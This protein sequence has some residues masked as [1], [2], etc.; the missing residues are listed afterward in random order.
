[1]GKKKQVMCKTCYRVMRSDNLNRHMKQHE[2]RNEDNP[3]TNIS[4]TNNIYNSTPPSDSTHKIEMKSDIN[5]EVLREHLTK[6][7]NEYQNKLALGKEIYK[8][9]GDGLIPHQA[10]ANEMKE[11]LDIYM[12]HQDDFRDVG[13]VE[14]KPWQDE[15]MKYMEP[16]D[17]DIF[18]IVG[19]DGNEGKS[20]FQKYVKSVF[21]TRRVM[22]GI[23]IKTSNASFFQ[24]LRKCPLVTADIFLFN[25][26]KSKKK[27]DEIN[28]DV[29]EKLK[30]GEAFASKYNS[31]QLKIKTPNVIM[32]FSNGKPDTKQ[33]A[34]DRWKLFYIENDALVEKQVVKNGDYSNSIIP[35]RKNIEDLTDEELEKLEDELC[36]D[37][38][39]RGYHVCNEKDED[40]LLLG[41]DICMLR[42]NYYNDDVKDKFKCLECSYASEEM[43]DVNKHFME[44]HRDTFRLPCKDCKMKFKTIKE[45]KMH[46]ARKHFKKNVNKNRTY[47]YPDST[48]YY[49]DENAY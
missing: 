23:D 42:M 19:K 41:I 18:W 36:L 1:M 17:R 39:W 27:F 37:L 48:A 33:L 29:F 38:C 2:K 43:E 12:E 24:A 3:V 10:L 25:I 40:N 28:Y 26:G 5:V 20:W 47:Y 44:N 15:L 22:S 46:Y 35:K 8:M 11:A 30:D 14:L 34:M 49:D 6:M 9:V 13:N 21:G 4:V 7:G 31:Q 45:L 32:V 16:C